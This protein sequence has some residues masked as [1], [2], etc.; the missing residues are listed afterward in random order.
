MD[1]NVSTFWWLAAGALVAAELAT[2]TF[3]LLMLSLGCAAGAAGALLGLGLPLQIVTAALLGGG[4]TALWH[5]KRASAPRSAPA[6]S[7]R[8]VNLDIGESVRVDTWGADG[9][10][11]AMYRGAAWTVRFAGSGA[12][13]PGEHIIVAIEGNRLSVAP[14]G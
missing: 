3:Y 14:R 12:P 13:A 1:W 7:N 11:R 10:A 9:L 5:F 8:D 4:A 2:G 6:A